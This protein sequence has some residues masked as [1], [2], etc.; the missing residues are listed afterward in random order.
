MFVERTKVTIVLPAELELE[1]E[2]EARIA[3]GVDGAQAC[4]ANRIFILP[5]MSFG[6]RARMQ[7]AMLKLKQDSAGA[8][9]QEIL[10]GSAQLALMQ[11]CVVDW[12]GPSFAGTPCTPE[13]IALLDPSE[14]LVEATLAEINRR[15]A[16]AAGAVSPKS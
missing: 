1:R 5:K 14:P 3:E 12:S 15:N 11:V 6:E 10:I 9:G 13:N 7:D 8:M 4:P 16:K 2:A